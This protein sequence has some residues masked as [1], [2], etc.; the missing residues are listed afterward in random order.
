MKIINGSALNFVRPY[1]KGLRQETPFMTRTRLLRL[2]FLYISQK[3][4]LNISSKKTPKFEDSNWI[5]RTWIF[6]LPLSAVT[7]H[8]STKRAHPKSHPEVGWHWSCSKMLRRRK[9]QESTYTILFLVTFYTASN[10]WTLME[11]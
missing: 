10:L 5:S 1:Q 3:S 4:T 11:L 2:Q 6:K 8:K 9:V 7:L